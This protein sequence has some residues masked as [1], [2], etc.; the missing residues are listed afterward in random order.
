VGRPR[1]NARG[2]S[3]NAGHQSEVDR[4][5]RQRTPTMTIYGW[6]GANRSLNASGPQIG[7]RQTTKPR[8][9][10]SITKGGTKTN[11]RSQ[12]GPKHSRNARRP[13][14]A[15]RKTIFLQ[16]SP[17]LVP[18]KRRTTIPNDSGPMSALR[19]M[20]D[21]SARAFGLRA[22]ES[23][24]LLGLLQA[25]GGRLRDSRACVGPA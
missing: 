11:H 2:C 14:M 23:T 10:P 7:L 13:R 21:I 9:R 22:I 12:K 19:Q 16:V 15:T 25:A 17:L 6:P 4:H 5:L 24:Q 1:S 20:F 18:T 8:P 3:C